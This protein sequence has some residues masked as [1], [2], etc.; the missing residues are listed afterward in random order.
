[1]LQINLDFVVFQYNKVKDGIYMC[2]PACYRVL[3]ADMPSR[4]PWGVAIFYWYV[5][6]FQV[7]YF[8]PHGRNMIS[9]Q[10]DY[11]KRRWFIVGCYIYPDN[12]SNV[13]SIIADIRKCTH[14]DALLVDGNSNIYLA[15]LEGNC[16]REEIAV[17][18]ATDG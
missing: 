4:H 10:L 12:A 1:M 9:F 14:R 6:H 3:V 7:E 11:D 17:V 15:A 18:I 13:E 2:V 8:Q 16:C 5:P